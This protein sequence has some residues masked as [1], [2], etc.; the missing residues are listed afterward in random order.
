MNKSYLSRRAERSVWSRLPQIVADYRLTNG[1]RTCWEWKRSLSTGYG[2]IHVVGQGKRVYA[3]R[4]VWEMLNGP[5][6]EGKELDHLCRNRCCINPAHL[7]PV[8]HSLN[9][10]RS[11]TPPAVNAKKT[12]CKRGHEFTP[13][14]VYSKPDGG[15]VCRRCELERS[16]RDQNYR[17][18]LPAQ[19]RTHCKHGHPFS[20]DN[21]RL[22]PRKRKGIEYTERVCRACASAGATAYQKRKQVA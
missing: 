12:H 11:F 21:L 15:R 6:P 22:M 20:G 7:E 14:N 19:L 5:V 10:R 13:E 1:E 4:V 3:H 16:R 18:N 2:Q 8:T 9:V 17:G